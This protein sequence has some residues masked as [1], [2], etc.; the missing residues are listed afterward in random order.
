MRACSLSSMTAWAV[1]S[2]TP[3][4]S[5]PDSSWS[6][7]TKGTPEASSVW[8]CEARS[9]GT[10][11][12]FWIP[13]KN[14]EV[15]AEMSTAPASAVPMEAPRLVTVFCR[16]P[17]SGLCSSLTAETVTAPSWEASAPMPSPAS[18]SGQV[19][20]SGPTP[21]SRAATRDTTPTK[22]SRKPIRTTRRGEASG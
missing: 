10:S 11:G 1:L 16:P 4:S 9:A 12:L 2:S 5:R 7:D 21:T 22:S 18:S 13:V 14:D 17:T 15:S 19:T 20:T 6:L 3:A 8:A